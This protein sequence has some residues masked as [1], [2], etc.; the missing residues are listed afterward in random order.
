MS[1]LDLATWLSIVVLVVGSTV[2]FV[3][4][5]ADVLRPSRGSRGTGA[6]DEGR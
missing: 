1:V 4:F 6:S 5:L 3:W 2:V